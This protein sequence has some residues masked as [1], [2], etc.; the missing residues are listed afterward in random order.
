MVPVITKLISI[1]TNCQRVV[2]ERR[3][4]SC[5]FSLPK[6]E[7]VPNS[8]TFIQVALLPVFLIFFFVASSLLPVPLLHRCF[9]FVGFGA[10]VPSVST[11]AWARGRSLLPMKQR[12]NGPWRRC[13]LGSAGDFG[14]PGYKSLESSGIVPVDVGFQLVC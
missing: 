6:S 14:T 12:K 13:Q 5:T 11:L 3:L 8:A 1:W 2:P 9:F 4:D 10:L 7:L